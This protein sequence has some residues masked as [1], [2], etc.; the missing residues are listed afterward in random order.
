MPAKEKEKVTRPILP[1]SNLFCMKAL[2]KILM[3]TL[4]IVGCTLI[5]MGQDS[6]VVTAPDPGTGTPDIFDKII[7]NI[8]LI[9]PAILGIYEILARLIPTLKDVSLVN[10]I[11]A[12][13]QWVLDKLIPNKIKKQ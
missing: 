8:V 10:K 7:N 3:L 13:L 11:I 5:M 1:K 2:S 4:A 6:T 12:I 9:I